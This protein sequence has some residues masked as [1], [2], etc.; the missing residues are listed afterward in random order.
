MMSW[1]LGLLLSSASEEK[2][3]RDKDEL[4]GSSLS[5]TTKKNQHKGFFL[6]LQKMEGLLS[7]FSFMC[8]VCFFS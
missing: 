3:V 2:K 5:L 1:D 7:S 6:G 8:F 4:G